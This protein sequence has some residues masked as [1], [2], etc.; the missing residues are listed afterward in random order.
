[1]STSDCVRTKC[2]FENYLRLERQNR[3]ARL[4]SERLH[5]P[6]C[7]IKPNSMQKQKAKYWRCKL[8]QD[9]ATNLCGYA[10]VTRRKPKEAF[11]KSWVAH[12]ISGCG[13]RHA[14]ALSKSVSSK[15]HGVSLCPF[16]NNS[17]ILRSSQYSWYAVSPL[18]VC[19]S[20]NSYH[21]K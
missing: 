14:C 3:T 1:M 18:D 19:P 11:P 12:L 4:C 2:K 9:T 7:K 20:S 8:N 10:Y 17:A 5:G 13:A 15:K 21:P 6:D 16:V